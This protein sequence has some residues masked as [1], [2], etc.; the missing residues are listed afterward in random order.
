[1][2]GLLVSGALAAAETLSLIRFGPI[3]PES[4]TTTF[5]C[6]VFLNFLTL[7]AFHIFVYPF[8]LSPLRNLPR[9]KVRGNILLGQIPNQYNSL[10]SELEK[11]WMLEH[12]DAP[13]IRYLT[14]LNKEVLLV[15]SPQAHKEVLQTQ[16][17]SFRKP[18][19]YQRIIGEIAGMGILFAEGEEHRRIRKMLIS[20]F[21]F[22]NIKRLLPFFQTKATELAN[23]ISASLQKSELVEVSGLL[24]KTTLDIVGLAALGYQL[25]SLSKPSILAES[26]EKIFECI[27]P[28]QVLIST[29]HRFIPVRSWLPLKVNKEYVHANAD[30]R[31]RLRQHIRQRKREFQ[32][33]KIL[34]EKQSRDLL[35]LM[36]EESKD[37][38]SEDEMLG[39]LLNFMSAGHETTAGAL[40]WALYALTLYPAMQ[41]R[42]RDEIKDGFTNS[43][44]P[45]YNEIEGL[46]FLNNFTKEVLRYYPP[47]PTFP[48]ETSIDVTIAGIPIPKG[49]LITIA[50]ATIQFNPLIWGPRAEDFDPDRFD[51]L[52]EAARDPFVLEAFS[53]GPRVC[54][55]KSFA[56]LEFKTIL[57][58]LV[59][60]FEFENTGP[61]EPQKSGPSLRPL[62]GMTMK[63]RAV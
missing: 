62:C 41:K 53:A 25:D 22:G 32:E 57:C 48:R 45:S 51:N 46:Q 12:P 21:S 30:V 47:A 27:T 42:L 39:Y 20:P 52:P 56:L 61:A 35:T 55:G 36:I 38:W 23:L 2:L 43:K 49:T 15:N 11:Q 24:A 60:R 33:G 1:M 4:F 14:F 50:P 28:L 34:G 37:T 8:Y 9:P 58:E 19:Y 63:V 31:T 10:P 54:I 3:K 18:L 17:Y 13:F 16:C 40:T 26:Y 59:R 29:I 5:A 7:Q 6:A 44:S